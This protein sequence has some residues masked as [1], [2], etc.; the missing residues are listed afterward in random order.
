MWVLVVLALITIWQRGR[1]VYKQAQAVYRKRLRESGR[2]GQR[3]AFGAVTWLP[4]PV[5][6]PAFGAIGRRRRAAVP[7]GARRSRHGSL[8]ANLRR[9]VGDAMP[10][11]EFA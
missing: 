2:A 4:G 11:D 10:D 7:P 1:F 5:T 8:A 3:R 6:W 9:V